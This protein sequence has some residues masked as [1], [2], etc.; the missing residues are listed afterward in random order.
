MNKEIVFS[1]DEVLRVF[2]LLENANDLF[3]Q[4]M[5]YEDIEMV[6]KFANDNYS[7]IHELYYE[8]LWNKLP[9]EIQEKIT[10]E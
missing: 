10:N 7:K 8:T 4:P 6:K 3:H 5:K 9:K 1:I 2:K